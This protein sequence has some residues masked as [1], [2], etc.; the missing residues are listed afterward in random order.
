MA[1]NGSL[2]CNSVQ[3]VLVLLSDAEQLSHPLLAV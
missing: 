2:V 1:V 3:D